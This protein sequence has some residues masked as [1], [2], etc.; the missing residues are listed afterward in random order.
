M[1]KRSRPSRGGSGPT[2]RAFLQRAAGTGL[3]TVA[4][5]ALIPEIG[6]AQ[7]GGPLNYISLADRVRAA[8][9][10]P[11]NAADLAI[12]NFAL[13]V[14]RLEAEFYNRNANQPY[15]TNPTPGT[16]LTALLV[17]SEETPAVNTTATALARF[18]LS[19]DHTQLFY[20]VRATGLSSLATAMHL[21]RAVRGQPGDIIY[22]LNTPVN[23]VSTGVIAVNPADVEMLLNQGFYI[24]IH[25]PNN[26]KGEIRGQVISAPPGIVTSTT[27]VLKNIVDEIRDHENAHVSLLVQ[28]LGEN[29]QAA[30]QFQN[31]DAL[32][33]QQFLTMAQNFEDISVS[34]YLG[35]VPLIQDRGIMAAAS[36]LMDVDARHAG[37]LRAYRRVANPA[38]GG[39]ATLTLTEDREAVNRARTREQVLSLIQPFI[40]AGPVSI[41]NPPTTTPPATTTPTTTPPATTTPA[42]T[43]PATT[44]AGGGTAPAGGTGGG[45]Y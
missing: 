35:Q 11:N 9:S 36:G 31:L 15:L 7:Q 8:S 33:L 26:P 14:E 34:A 2:R 44:P 37:G 28:A 16:A 38:E 43:P 32:T 42:I 5:I 40:A 30:P 6:A 45:P 1:V 39:D 22:P 41:G 25:T 23:G 21:H 24:N 29:A 10:P 4:G 19:P 3:A 17:G 27:P 18:T 12:L 20:D 13:T